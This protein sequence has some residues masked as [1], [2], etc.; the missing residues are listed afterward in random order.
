VRWR[1][2]AVLVSDHYNAG[3]FVALQ[4]SLDGKPEP[5]CNPAR[6]LVPFEDGK[7]ESLGP[8]SRERELQVGRDEAIAMSTS[9]A[10]RRETIAHVE[11]AGLRLGSGDAP[12]RVL[13]RLHRFAWHPISGLTSFTVPGAG[14]PVLRHD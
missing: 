7:T 8:V 2:G 1:I 14:A 10:V 5:R 4:D 11:R 13:E 9:H 3:P 12:L 6:A